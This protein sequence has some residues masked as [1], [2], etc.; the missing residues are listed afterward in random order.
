[1]SSRSRRLAAVAVAAVAGA[2]LTAGTASPARAPHVK[3]TKAL[4]SCVNTSTPQLSRYSAIGRLTYGFSARGE[5]VEPDLGQTPSDL[6]ASAKGKAGKYFSA[7]VPVWFHVVT[8]G[9]LGNVSNKVISD[10]LQVLNLSFAGFYG[11]A[12]SGFKFTLAG[13]DRT[14]NADWYNASSSSNA[15]RDMKR[16]LQKGGPNTLN[17]YTA[18]AGPGLLGYA[19][20]PDIVTKPGQAYLD[21]IVINWESMPGASTSFAGRYDLGQTL[22]HETGHW[23]DLEHTFF[24]ACNAK[25]D[26]VDD[27]PAEGTAT[28]GCPAGKDTCPKEPGLDPIHNF[29][30]YSYDACYEEF[31]AGQVQRMRD[32]WLAYRAP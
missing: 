8:D 26:F 29:M 9:S 27:T 32:A 1:M 6:P 2:L 4:V 19:Y 20:L 11:G 13:I 28:S 16:A 21:G 10:Q 14:N 22:T 18:T 24:G 31:T 7:T 12:K 23:F 17:V 5:R 3:N 30:D 15:A 25:G